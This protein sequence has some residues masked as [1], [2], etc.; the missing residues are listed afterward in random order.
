LG[1][2]AEKMNRPLRKG[3]YSLSGANREPLNSADDFDKLASVLSDQALLTI[4]Q[5]A[6]ASFVV[7]PPDDAGSQ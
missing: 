2:A 5:E 4:T 6:Q 3:R 1:S 7:I